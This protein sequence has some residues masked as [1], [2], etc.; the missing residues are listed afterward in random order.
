VTYGRP[1]SAAAHLRAWCHDAIAAHRAEGTIPTT[2]RFIF[3]EAVMAGV[4]PKHATGARRADQ[5]V[6]DALTWLREH[7]LIGWDEILDRSRH[8][9]DF[10][11][12]RSALDAAITY[13]NVVRLDAWQ[14]APP[15][16]IVESES[17][18]GLFENVA[19]ELRVVLVPVRG[20]ASASMLVNDVLPFVECGSDEVLYVGDHDKAGYDIEA[21]AQLRLEHFADT[22]LKWERIALTAT[23]VEDYALPLVSR[24][25]GRNG[26][27]Y[28]VAECEA[29]PQAVLTAMVRDA[30]ADRLP[31]PLDHVHE[32][33]Q[34]QRAAVLARLLDGEDDA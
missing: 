23:Q 4:V 5:A 11:G 16:L 19:A 12:E 24:T 28:E 7:G 17:L 3:Y 33:E 15:L 22:E 20:Q 34:R 31:E 27:T 18:A 32:R 6:T 29:M 25:D 2:C 13:M 14:G 9:A 8:V 21:S 10:T 26:Q 30:L 1:N